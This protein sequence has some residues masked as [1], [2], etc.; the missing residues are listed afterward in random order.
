LQAFREGRPW[1]DEEDRKILSDERPSEMELSKQ[2]GRSIRA[3]QH[4]RNRL[5]N[6]EATNGSVRNLLEGSRQAPVRTWKPPAELSAPKPA[7][8]PPL[9]P[10][11]ARFRALAMGFSPHEGATVE[12]IQAMMAR[13]KP[14]YDSGVRKGVF[15]VTAEFGVCEVT[16][17]LPGPLKALVKLA[18]GQERYVTLELLSRS[19][20]EQRR[21][22][23]RGGR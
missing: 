8:R 20:R 11:G 2:I 21:S 3:I 9:T 18:S 19:Q 4:R 6:N 10:M 13:Y 17:I 23:R 7:P 1:S 16:Q 15:V 22:N 12:E 5:K 14:F